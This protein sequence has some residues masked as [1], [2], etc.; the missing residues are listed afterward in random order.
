MGTV[1]SL[2][3]KGLSHDECWALFKQRAFANDQE[4]YLNL[5]PIGKQIVRKCGGVPLA[6]KSLG[7][8]IRRSSESK[9]PP[10]YS[11]EKCPRLEEN[12]KKD[13]GKEW[14]KIA[15]IVHIYI[16][17]PELRKDNNVA[18]SSCL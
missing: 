12:C 13:T 14:A 15:H 3:L 16:G 11:I 5:L 4:D 9:H 6:A 1:S 7:S 2:H 17:S 8:L 10:A 18:S